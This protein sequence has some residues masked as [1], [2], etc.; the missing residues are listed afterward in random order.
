MTK[1]E[2]ESRLESCFSQTEDVLPPVL[3][4]YEMEKSAE[5]KRSRRAIILLSVAGL[6]WTVVIIFCIAVFVSRRYP[7]LYSTACS[8][9][10][11]SRAAAIPAL[12]LMLVCGVLI[13]ALLSQQRNKRESRE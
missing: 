12:M 1:E 5:R 13:A 10:T 3:S 2:L 8:M 9:L 6:L 4:V 7:E 11:S